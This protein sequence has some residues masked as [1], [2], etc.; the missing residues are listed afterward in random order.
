MIIFVM[1]LTTLFISMLVSIIVLSMI[2][3]FVTILCLSCSCFAKPAAP[4]AP[5]APTAAVFLPLPDFYHVHDYHG[6]FHHF[7]NGHFRCH[8]AVHGS[9]FYQ[10]DFLLFIMMMFSTSHACSASYSCASCCSFLP[11]LEEWLSSFESCTA[12]SSLL[13]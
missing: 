9:Y 1:M 8:D 10:N 4:A 5:A 13:S 3:T 2:T 7:Y 11:L 6:S 12:F